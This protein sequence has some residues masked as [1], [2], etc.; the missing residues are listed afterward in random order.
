[1]L[2]PAT[3]TTYITYT[4]RIFCLTTSR[5]HFIVLKKQKRTLLYQLLNRGM[6]NTFDHM[7]KYLGAHQGNI[8][9]IVQAIS[10]YAAVSILIYII[11]THVLKN[12]NIWGCKLRFVFFNT[13]L[14]RQTN[15]SRF[16]K[17]AVGYFSYINCICCKNGDIEVIFIF[18][19]KIQT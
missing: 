1:M 17:K 16:F 11:C 13:L 19:A 3:V 9:E 14:L 5:H 6:T 4:T 2:G 7:S 8:I 12:A 10:M 15:F 18:H